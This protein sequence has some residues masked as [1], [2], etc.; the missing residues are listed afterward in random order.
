MK[1]LKF[2]IRNYKSIVDS[3]DCYFSDKL[4]I[5]AG[6]NESGKTTILEA[7]EDFHEEKVIR[8]S[9]I[10]IDDPSLK[11][12]VTVTFRMTVDDLNAVYQEAELQRTV[13]EVVDVGLY[14]VHGSPSYF[15][16]AESRKVLGWESFYTEAHNKVTRL[17]TTPT[18]PKFTNQTLAAY[19]TELEAFRASLAVDSGDLDKID[20]AISA[21]SRYLEREG[22]IGKFVKAF[23]ASRLPYFILFSSFE[24]KFPD[25]I[26]LADLATNEW[27]ADL[28]QVSNFNRE[29]ISSSVKQLQANHQ[30]AVNTEFTEKFD[31][32]WTQDPI[33]LKVQKNETINFWIVEDGILHLPSQR[34]QGQQWYL[35]FFIKVV[36]RISEAKPNVIL[37]DEPGLFLHARAQKDL[38]NVLNNHTSNF[39]VVFSTHSPYL[40]TEDNLE[41]VRLVEKKGRKTTVLGKIHA[42]ETADKETLTPI[43][44]AI[45]LGVNDSITNLDQKNNVV[46]EGPE[47]VFYLQAFRRLLPIEDRPSTNF[48]NG[49]GAGNMGTVGA[50]LEGWGA[51]VYYMY[52][53]DQG[54]TDGAKALRNDWKVLPELI[55]KCTSDANASIAD[56]LSIP[57]FKKFVLENENA[58]YT[59]MNSAYLKKSKLEKVLLARQF[60]QKVKADD[61][62]IQVDDD[63]IRRIK[64]LFDEIKFK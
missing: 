28:E 51:D 30:E 16:T 20:E 15:L 10:P 21:I 37:I 23:V 49:G 52:D 34:S 31:K 44:T 33:C 32:Y 62:G 12:E 64:A 39:P 59:S 3:G 47:D 48:V 19:K 4:T 27:A 22:E 26:A 63:S 7:L 42:H 58:K 6:K 53:N 38:L 13:T 18:K 25:E 8:D 35:S 56:I 36:A 5:L 29:S 40:I 17:S 14:R 43:L 54:F 57:D 61:G 50:I 60:L 1:L 11:P 55:K 46:V 9:A 41:N 45:G 2:R 24:D